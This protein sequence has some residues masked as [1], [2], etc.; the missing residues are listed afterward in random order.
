MALEGVSGGDEELGWE[1]FGGAGDLEQTDIH[2]LGSHT[3]NETAKPPFISPGL[4]QFIIVA[5]E[6]SSLTYLDLLLGSLSY[7]PPLFRPR[8]VTGGEGATDFPFTG[9]EA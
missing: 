3:F 5:S 6:S 9:G 1:L 4:A 7:D 8:G 2:M